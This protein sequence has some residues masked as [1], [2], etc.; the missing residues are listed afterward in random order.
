MMKKIIFN[1]LIIVLGSFSSQAQIPGT[2]FFWQQ[3]KVAP[4]SSDLQVDPFVLPIL[5]LVTCGSPAVVWSDSFAVKISNVGAIPTSGPI[6][7]KIKNRNYNIVDNPYLKLTWDATATSVTSSTLGQTYAVDNGNWIATI[8]SNGDIDLVYNGAPLAPN[9]EVALGFG[10][11]YDQSANTYCGTDCGISS[12][13]LG[14]SIIE[15]SGGEVNF[16]NNTQVVFG[17]TYCNG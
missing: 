13:G 3:K 6:T 8:L 2:P 17:G 7:V 10:V 14:V 11:Y 16:S 5:P 12:M 9:Q 4:I 15:G 1:F